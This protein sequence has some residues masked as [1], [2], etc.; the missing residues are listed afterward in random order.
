[1]INWYNKFKQS[2]DE[3]GSNFEYDDIALNFITIDFDKLEQWEKDIYAILELAKNISIKHFEKRNDIPIK[4]KNIIRK[5]YNSRDTAIVARPDMI[6]VGAQPKILELNFDSS[7][8]EGFYEIDFIQNLLS[9]NKLTNKP[10]DLFYNGKYNFKRFIVNTVG[11]EFIAVDQINIA[12]VVYSDMNRYDLD[13]AQK[14]LEWINEIEG[15]RCHLKT[16]E[17]L[18][19]NGIFVTDGK[20]SFQL[21][22]IYPT[23]IDTPKRCESLIQF[24]LSLKNIKTLIVSDPKD[25]SVDCK[26]SLA[27]LKENATDSIFTNHEISI[28]NQYIP[29]TVEIKED[30]YVTF[31]DT[32]TDLRILLLYNK[33]KFVLKRTHSFYGKNVIIGAT[34][35]EE[36]WHKF[37]KYIYESKNEIWVA[38]EYLVSEKVKFEYYNDNTNEIE[39][40]NRS[41]VLSPYFLGNNIC[42]FLVRVEKHEM[43]KVLSR[44]TDSNMGIAFVKYST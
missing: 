40:K 1:M 36:V 37:I 27:Y 8:I 35:P 32:Y 9:K 21:L 25:L 7:S 6:L 10:N 17:A 19:V 43:S 34:T 22:Y 4:H 31:D 15:Y 11:S 33:E 23:L 39:S 13:M 5:F 30:K 24:L 18:W 44:H 29:W 14:M 26:L 38:Q 28:I 41:Y 20:R 3:L 16:P 42:N 2:L 12:F